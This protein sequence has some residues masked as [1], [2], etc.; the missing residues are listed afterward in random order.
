MFFSFP[1]LL[2]LDQHASNFI[3]LTFS[4][5][6]PFP[7]RPLSAIFSRKTEQIVNFISET[8]FL[9]AGHTLSQHLSICL[10]IALPLLLPVYSPR[11]HFLPLTCEYLWPRL[12]QVALARLEA[13]SLISVL[14][15]FLTLP[16][17]LSPFLSLFLSA[18]LCP[19]YVVHFI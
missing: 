1:L 2:L 19:L 15:F 17:S 7:V 12:R 13:T 10:Q 14:C 5:L 3:P 9:H 8:N 4:P 18:F 6:P 16:L 11:A